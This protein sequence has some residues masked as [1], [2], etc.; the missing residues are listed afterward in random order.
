MHVSNPAAVACVLAV[1]VLFTL[2]AVAAPGQISREAAR[3]SIMAYGV[4]SLDDAQ[5]QQLKEGGW[6]LVLSR[7]TDLDLLHRHDLRALLR[8]D[9]LKPETLDDPARRAELDEFI[10]RVKH[11]PAL[12][13]YWIV[14]EP[15]ASR[16]EALGRLLDYLRE[17]DPAHPGYINL[18]P[19][20]ASN[21]QLGTEG[22]VVAA[23]QQYLREFLETVQP[24][25]L[26]YDHYHFRAGGLDGDQYFLNLSLVRQAALDAGVPFLNFIQACTW[27]PS[28]REPVSSEL[29]FLTYTSLAYGASAL[30]HYTY[31]DR[32]PH[33]GCP[34]DAQGRTTALWDGMKGSNHEFLAIRRQLQHL[35]SLGAYHVGMIPPGAEELPPDSPFALD[36]PVGRVAY[37]PPEPLHGMLLGYFGESADPTHVLVVNLD[38]RRSTTTTVRGR[39][40]LEIFSARREKWQPSSEG[41]RARLRL[42]PGGGILLRVRS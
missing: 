10:A 40:P 28:M 34:V 18:F 7:E 23:Y 4:L 37:T 8:S 33:T 24:D 32:G 1:M 27:T 16:F 36:P 35:R 11:H 5:A 15:D 17:R 42:Q 12:S 20:Y 30:A 26:S 25:Y 31:A 22:D 41:A 19:T 14:D 9:L 3:A 13:M 2:G 6:N 39:G 38:Y 29:R 21:E